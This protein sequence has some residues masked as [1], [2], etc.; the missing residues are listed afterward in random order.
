VTV[1]DLGAAIGVD[2]SDEGPGIPDEDPLARAPGEGIGLP[3][4]RRL[5]EAESG[6]LWL[7]V[8]VP[9]TFTLVLPTHGE[10]G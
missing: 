5:A 4:A 6:R 1:R 8:P 7:A 9:P 10:T 3:L 2:V